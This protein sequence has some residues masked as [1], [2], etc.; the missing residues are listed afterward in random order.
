MAACQTGRQ[1]RR[2]RASARFPA[3]VPPAQTAASARPESARQSARHTSAKAA[4]NH[5]PLPSVRR[6]AAPPHRR[7]ILRLTAPC[8]GSPSAAW[9]AS[10]AARVTARRGD[11]SAVPPASGKA[12]APVPSVARFRP[13]RL[14]ANGLRSPGCAAP[15]CAATVHPNPAA[16]ANSAAPPVPARL[17]ACTA[18][19]RAA[20]RADQLHGIGG[21]L[22]TG[23]TASA[24]RVH[25][26]FR[27]WS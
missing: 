3:A 19:A 23:G 9:T 12:P 25:P 13:A 14:W 11:N 10:P 18:P 20:G 27:R 16:P 1:T 22:Q 21:F 4:A 8:A 7:Q 15:A 24:R 2:H 5:A 17:A 6:M 26:R